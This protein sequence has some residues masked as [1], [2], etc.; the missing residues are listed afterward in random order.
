M[1][2]TE[3]TIDTF[4]RAAYQHD[5]SLISEEDFVNVNIQYLDA[6][7]LF[8]TREF[9]L[10][11]SIQNLRNRINCITL[12]VNIHREYLK[13]FGIAYLPKLDMFKHYGYTLTWVNKEDFERQLNMIEAR[14]KRYV[15]VLA[16]KE[17]ELENIKKETTE[18]TDLKHSRAQFNKMII[19]LQKLNYKIDKRSTT[20]EDLATMIKDNKETNENNGTKHN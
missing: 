14:E 15:S 20:M 9:E 4:M 2:F 17:K 8:L 11:V 13:E 18:T 6:S 3:C 7:G 16:N 19:S 5:Y 10:R 1:D 12:G